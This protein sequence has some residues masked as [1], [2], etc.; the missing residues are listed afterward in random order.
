MLQSSAVNV[1]DAV[2]TASPEVVTVF[3]TIFKSATATPAV[4]QESHKVTQEKATADAKPDGSDHKI[5]ELSDVEVAALPVAKVSEQGPD[6][7]I[8]ASESN[9][10]GA[11]LVFSLLMAI[12]LAIAAWYLAV[13]FAMAMVLR[14][15]L[16]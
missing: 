16:R 2:T 8:K 1:T 6:F 14:P 11:S 9:A 15:A 10:I 3:H 13:R 5:K 4:K 7:S 12:L